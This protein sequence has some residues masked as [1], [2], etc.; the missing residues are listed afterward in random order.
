MRWLLFI[1]A[2]LAI[3]YSLKQSEQDH[4]ACMKIQSSAICDN[5]LY[6]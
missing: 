1:V 5:P 2:V 3:G 4:A 6:Q